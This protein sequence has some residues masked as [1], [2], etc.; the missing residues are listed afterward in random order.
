MVSV[1]LEDKRLALDVFDEC[2]GQLLFVLLPPGIG[3][4][5]VFDRIVPVLFNEVVSDDGEVCVLFGNIHPLPFNDVVFVD[6][7]VAL[8]IP[9]QLVIVEP[10]NFPE[11]CANPS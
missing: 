9:V 8:L 11:S 1:P 10:Y 7:E 2:V 4:A 5:E 6:G 3:S